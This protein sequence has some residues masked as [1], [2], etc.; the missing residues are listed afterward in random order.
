MFNKIIA[1]ESRREHVRKFLI[2]SRLGCLIFEGTIQN[3]G[4]QMGFSW[5]AKTSVIEPAA[6]ATV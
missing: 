4:P 1:A 5:I 2:H 3:L 6:E